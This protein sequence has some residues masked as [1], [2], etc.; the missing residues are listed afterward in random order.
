MSTRED[1][2]YCQ[3]YILSP[4]SAHAHIRRN[5]SEQPLRSIDNPRFCCDLQLEDVPLTLVDVRNFQF[6][7]IP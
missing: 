4:V 7:Y 2:D 1:S 6:N 3:H 5:C